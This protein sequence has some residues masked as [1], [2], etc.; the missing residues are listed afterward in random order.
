MTTTNGNAA[1]APAGGA[2]PGDIQA[3]QPLPQLNV[4]AQYVKDLSGEN[5]VVIGG[6]TYTIRTRYSFSMYP[7]PAL[8]AYATEY[9]LDARHRELPARQSA[10][11]H[12]HGGTR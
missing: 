2:Q 1:D 6:N 4:L 7:T 3:P 8:N 12:A 5:T 10:G 9:I 11:M